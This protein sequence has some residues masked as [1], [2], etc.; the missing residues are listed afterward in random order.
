MV[1]VWTLVF[2]V[3]MAEYGK[4]WAVHLMYLYLNS[5]GEQQPLISTSLPHSVRL[6]CIF[7]LTRA[8]SNTCI[9]FDPRLNLSLKS[10]VWNDL[11]GNLDLI[12]QVLICCYYSDIYITLIK[13]FNSV[14]AFVF[15]PTELDAVV[16]G[17][18]FTIL[19]TTLPSPRL[20]EIVQKYGNLSEL[21][22]HIHEEYF[23]DLQKD[24]WNDSEW[25]TEEEKY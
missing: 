12:F 18:L 17:H 21:C 5:K 15:S 24:G 1:G 19:T 16:F 10:W 13:E 8:F 7:L 11:T 6:H 22:R 20:A 23:K 9:T 3:Y 2:S 25:S 4:Y 14:A